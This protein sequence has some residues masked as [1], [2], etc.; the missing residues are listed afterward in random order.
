MA[1]ILDTSNKVPGAYVKVTLGVGQ[2]SGAAIDSRVMLY[3]NKTSTGVATVATPYQI[4]SVA[5]ARDLFGA[6][7]ELFRMARAALTANPLCQLFGIAATE[8]AG[9][10]ASGT[11]TFGSGP[12]SKASTVR[13][14]VGGEVIFVPVAATDTVS[15]IATA[16]AAA[17]NKMSDWPV[18]ASALAGA[19]TLTAK[20]KGPRGN[21]IAYFADLEVSCAV[22]VTLAAARLTSGATSDSLQNASDAT[23]GSRYRY[24][25]APGSDTTN[26]GILVTRV[27]ATAQPAEGRRELVVFATYDTPANA[28]TLATGRNDA[29]AQC[30]WAEGAWQ[31]PGE[32]AAAVAAVRAAK[33]ATD[34][35]YNLDG[36]VIPG[37][38]PRRLEADKPTASELVGA[39]NNGVTPLVD[40]S[41]GKVAICRSITTK[42]Q[43]ALGNPD[44]RTI[45]TASVV[46]PDYIA[47]DI[48]ATW[49]GFVSTAGAKL[50]ENPA[51]GKA[52]P[53]GVV[54]PKMARD[55]LYGRL[56]AAEESALVENV[57]ARLAELT[58]SINQVASGR[59]DASIPVDVVKLLHQFGAD[60]RQV[61]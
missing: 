6:G 38:V 33:E 8:S 31:T 24:H 26:I 52:P 28:I 36:E 29:R 22:T 4:A 21:D 45:D 48:A 54:T 35:A 39:L 14:F 47:D 9:Q 18:T 34:A 19:V 15:A 41:G 32:M 50:G 55:F 16:V 44:Y 30:V 43:D 1:T 37:L 12:A 7:S 23:I 25:V 3:G 56:K 60:V 20:Q 5:D 40:V 27:N 42:S 46:V 53:A 13:V 49:S 58:V 11:I 61:G 57:D 2:A 51:E 17:I 10:A 59:L